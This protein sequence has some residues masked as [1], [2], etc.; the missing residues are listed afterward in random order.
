MLQS[1]TLL[2]ANRQVIAAD[3]QGGVYRLTTSETLLQGGQLTATVERASALGTAV[4]VGCVLRLTFA[5]LEAEEWRVTRV[6]HAYGDGAA[7]E[8]EAE[9][10][11]RDLSRYIVRRRTAGGHWDTSFTLYNR[12]PAGLLSE[13]MMSAPAHFVTG[14]TSGL[15]AARAARLVTMELSG[16]TILEALQRICGDLDCEWRTR[17]LTAP[18]RWAI[19]LVDPGTAAAGTRVLQASASAVSNRLN[20]SAA[21][22]LSTYASRIIPLL[23]GG[24]ATV[25]VGAAQHPVLSV[26]GGGTQ[27]ML[28][29]DVIPYSGFGVATPTRRQ[30]YLGNDLRGWSQ[31]ALA[32]ESG[33]VNVSPAITGLQAGE[34]VRFALDDEGAHLDGLDAD[35]APFGPMEMPIIVEGEPVP[36]LLRERGL[37]DDLSVWAAGLPQGWTKVGTPAV[38]EST[39][40]RFAKI[41]GKAARVVAGIGQGLE[42]TPIDTAA[43]Y[44][45][46]WAQLVAETGAVSLE[47]IDANGVS[48]PRVAAKAE[49]SGRTTTALA[50]GVIEGFTSP[51]R[52]RVVATAPG[53]T[54]YLDAATLAE[55][56]SGEASWAAT[57]GPTDLWRRA[58][59]FM[60]EQG[61]ARWALG[62]TFIDLA[63][64]FPGA[65]SRVRCGDVVAITET[66]PSGAELLGESLRVTQIDRTLT[67]DGLDVLTV[68]ARFDTLR[69]TLL[70]LF[71]SSPAR[72]PALP[73]QQ[74][75][76]RP[77]PALD[78]AHAL[79]ADEATITL[80]VRSS[81]PEVSAPTSYTLY[82]DHDPDSFS[83]SQ[84][85]TP[86]ALGAWEVYETSAQSPHTFTVRRPQAGEPP[87]AMRFYAYDE[88]SRRASAVATV[89]VAPASVAIEAL[90][91][92]S[93]ATGSFTLTITDAEQLLSLFRYRTVRSDV[94]SSWTDLGLPGAGET[95]TAGQSSQLIRTRSLALAEKH[96]TTVE[97]ELYAEDAIG[98]YIL[99]GTSRLV[100]DVDDEPDLRSV[101][102]YAGGTNGSGNAPV[103]LAW[104]GDEDT[105]GVVVAVQVLTDPALPSASWPQEAD[106][107]TVLAG[108]SGE[109]QLV[110][111]ISPGQSAHVAVR[112][113]RSA[114]GQ[115]PSIR[116]A[117]RQVV[118]HPKITSA[119]QLAAGLAG[120]SLLAAG[121]GKFRTTCVFTSAAPGSV[122]WTAGQII[123]AAGNTV[124]ISAGS[125]T[126][127]PEGSVR[128]I[129]WPG[130]S[131]FNVTSNVAD[132]LY[133]N[134]LLVAVAFGGRSGSNAGIVVQDGSKMQVAAAQLTALQLSAIAADLGLVTAGE[135]RLGSGVPG[136]A[137]TPFTGIRIYKEGTTYRVA[138][139]KENVVQAFMDSDGVLRFGPDGQHALNVVGAQ[140]R[141]TEGSVN[142]GAQLQWYI[143]RLVGGQMQDVQVAAIGVHEGNTGGPAMSLWAEGKLYLGSDGD[144]TITAGG[145]GNTTGGVDI[146]LIPGTDGRVHLPYGYVSAFME[147]EQQSGAPAGTP[148]STRL[149]VFAYQN[150]LHVQFP[151]GNIFRLNHTQVTL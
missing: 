92:Q 105:A 73:P 121:Y 145:D 20:L 48:H 33:Q 108:Q 23:R 61:G 136:D 80:V 6:R 15:S 7:F 91:T 13:V 17:K 126:G 140:L 14:S 97:V 100:F 72:P 142:P 35:T 88:T 81:D 90:T 11:W 84:A 147:F 124:N 19:D 134:T 31:V 113:A 83:Y 120:S 45:F 44:L 58:V 71:G 94:P 146:N 70:D 25:G 112:G 118:K 128:F 4:I 54:F 99:L 125:A 150:N 96:V 106:F 101:Q 36:N 148:S 32:F 9:P 51:V 141:A 110:A 5:D 28:P 67:G 95:G 151:N 123:T 1:L 39:D 129:T 104:R 42:T 143:E 69:K 135:L 24:E 37:T 78:V 55:Q 3:V 40:G 74:V 53:T 16:A 34:L 114:T 26:T 117:V 46:A 107:T 131:L 30:L 10:L 109:A 87:L 18:E 116:P 85:P 57:M 122:S 43:E 103:R 76:L 75:P 130:G 49:T 115:G 65:Y 2:D 132:T 127:I 63:G 138:G 98:G 12:S 64:V 21:L 50:A 77:A 22:D 149:R 56:G 27:V 139:Y 52:L 119:N 86:L 82:S 41:G 29:A 68:R 59:A 62:A 79:T 93:G 38:T 137:Q 66:A 60:R 8:V 47:V 102:A 111:E 144:V 89:T 133:D